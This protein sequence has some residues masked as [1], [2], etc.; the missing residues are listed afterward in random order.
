MKV[1]ANDDGENVDV[2]VASMRDFRDNVTTLSKIILG[3]DL[4]FNL[5][6]RIRVISFKVLECERFKSIVFSTKESYVPEG[7]QPGGTEFTH[8]DPIEETGRLYIYLTTVYSFLGEYLTVEEKQ[9]HINHCMDRYE[10][11]IRN[12]LNM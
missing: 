8:E 11:L 4:K 7:F 6:G 10:R 2:F 3:N 12:K 1:H 9:Q 5:D